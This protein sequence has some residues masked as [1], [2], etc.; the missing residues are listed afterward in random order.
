MNSSRKK[1]RGLASGRFGA[2]ALSSILFCFLGSTVLSV[3]A[4]PSSSCD[5]KLTAPNGGEVWPEGE[6]RKILW[7]RK[8]PDCGRRVKLEYSTDDG[9]TWT[10]IAED[11][12]NDGEWMW[13]IPFEPTARALIKIIDQ[14]NPAYSD[15]SDANFTI[16]STRPATC[17]L[18]LKSP[19][20]GE[21]WTAGERKKITWTANG[22]ACGKQVRLDFSAN[23]GKYWKPI[24]RV[25]PNQGEYNWIVPKATTARARVKVTDLAAQKYHDQ[26]DADF[27]ISTSGPPGPKD[28][29]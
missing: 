20:G 9:A 22:T 28:R 3:S 5:L 21:T 8:G 7:T 14:A 6:V 19:N 23:G 27:T 4:H 10:V 13:A 2:L 1:T 18:T 25:L 11:T 29:D 16:L 26:S 15:L 24:V 17:A 12:L